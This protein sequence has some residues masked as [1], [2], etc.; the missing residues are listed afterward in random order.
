MRLAKFILVVEYEGTRYHG[1]QWQ[2]GV[3]TI[4]DEVEKA[5]EH[6][7][8]RGSRVMAA[9]R[10]DAGVHASGQVA[11]FW[12]ETRLSPENM[13]RALNRYLPGDIAVRKAYEVGRDF[14]VR[15]DAV[16]REYCYYIFRR[17]ERSPFQRRFALQVSGK[18]NIEAMNQA[19]Q[20][21]HGEHDFISFATSLEGITS[22]QRKVYQAQVAEN[23][24][25]VIFRMEADS[26]LPHQV[27]NTVGM[28]LRVGWG[29]I[30]VSLFG[31]AMKEK[32]LGSA[33][34]MAPARGLCLTRVTY[35][36][37]FEVNDENL[38]S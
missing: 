5:I 38:Y 27:R 2:A 16:S 17:R 36:K 6:F 21:L 8:R 18:L 12:A 7:C 15:G 22:T 34:P 10:T 26:F 29:K 9:S 20:M 19:C 1:F 11:S 31:Q 33:G 23:N 32:A 30:D 3:P 25:M 35:A 24:E 4:Q 13:V 14:D 28:L 37:S